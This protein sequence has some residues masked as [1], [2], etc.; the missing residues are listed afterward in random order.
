VFLIVAL[1]DAYGILGLLIASPLA[2]AI[3]VLLERLIATQPG[4]TPRARSLAEIEKRIARVRQRLV[5]MPPDEAAQLA[6]VVARLDTLALQA[7]R[8]TGGGR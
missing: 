1:V 6:S 7:R 5:V 4:R 3:Q 8:A 2:A